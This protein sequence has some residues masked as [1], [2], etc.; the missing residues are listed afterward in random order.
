MQDDDRSHKAIKTNRL[1]R[2]ASMTR[3]GMG[4]ATSVM[5]SSAAGLSLAV[6]R[7]GELRGM[8]TKVGQMAGLV[9]ANLPPELRAK[10]GAALA[11]LRDRAA[12][13]P[14]RDVARL[15]EED[16]GA[17]PEVLFAR[18]EREPFASAS[19]GQVHDAVHHDQRQ[20]A[21]KVQHP[22]I[23]EAF[24][25]DL[26]NVASLAR[27]ATAFV[28][29]SATRG[30]FLEEVK[31]GFLAELDYRREAENL[32]TFQRLTAGDP[33]LELPS[34][35]PDCSSARVLSM[36]FLSGASVE[37]ARSY[38]DGTRRRQAAAVRRFV[39]SAL[40][41]HGVLYAD[42]HAGNFLFREAGTVGVLD[43]GS[44]FHFDAPRRQAFADYLD[45]L[46]ASD[47]SAFAR[48]LRNVFG[49]DN[50]NVVEAI[51]DVQFFAV[52][53]LVRGEPIHEERVRAITGAAAQMKSKLLRERFSL[54]SFLPFFMRTMLATN[55]LLAALDAPE[56]GPLGRLSPPAS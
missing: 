16:L 34:L 3:A 8:G 52:G 17:P 32:R 11:R 14:Y 55:A 47:R 40:A 30:K 21:V 38:P 23:R 39:F 15:I 2:L 41:D 12:R 25:N 37:V 42:A 56:S 51:A 46:A 18:F 4:A 19:L 44:A 49:L 22:G 54:P 29:P 45:A 1:S 53:G 31:Q 24:E 48:A 27:I 33:D 10:V 28:M 50:D 26:S 13:S 9:E 6:D 5:V 35:V 7:L 36:T 43:F 20:L